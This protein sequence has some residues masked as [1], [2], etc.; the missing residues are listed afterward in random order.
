MKYD[1]INF[2]STE[3]VVNEIVTYYWKIFEKHIVDYSTTNCEST[4]IRETNFNA[5]ELSNFN[6]ITKDV[7]S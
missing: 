1:L 4:E 3:M 6:F 7:Y 2:F 5:S